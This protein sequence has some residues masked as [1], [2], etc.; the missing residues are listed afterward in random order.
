VKL[1]SNKLQVH[2]TDVVLNSLFVLFGLQSTGAKVKVCQQAWK[3]AYGI[4]NDRVQTVKQAALR[5]NIRVVNA[6]SGTGAL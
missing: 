6:G 5:G 1:I 4:G 2:P 3:H